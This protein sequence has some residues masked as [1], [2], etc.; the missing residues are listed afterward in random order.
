MKLI[1][2]DS[3][4]ALE[5]EAL[6]LLA[7][8]FRQ[9][10]PPPHGVMLTGGRTVL[11]LYEK[12]CANPCPIDEGLH[13]LISDERHVPT[14]SPE[15]N[16]AA[17]RRMVKSLGIDKSQVMRVRTSLTLREAA[18]DYDTQLATF[19]DSGGRIT[20]GI[21]GL[22][23]DGHLASLFEMSHLNLVEKRWAIPVPRV[24]GPDR[25]SV[26][27]DLL[28]QVERIV[29]LAVGAE[30]AEIIERIQQQPESV[31]ASAALAESP[32]TEIWHSESD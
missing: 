13:L 21:L 16:F 25:I 3:K 8:H 9:T 11:G 4:A 18:R 14:D 12:L 20:L 32:W 6:K 17:M 22:G 23:A 1:N 5:Q 24:P 31:V 30:K 19:L 28:L 15:N 26:T 29:F 10:G 27:Q 7:D 2:F